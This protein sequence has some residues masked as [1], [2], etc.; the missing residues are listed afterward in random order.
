MT[1]LTQKLIAGAVAWTSC[2][3]TEVN[4][5]ASGNAV[6]S[7]VQIDNSGNL[8]M[9]MDVSFSLGSVTSAGTPYL[10][11]YWYPL[12]QDGSTYGDSRFASS[13]TAFPP[14]NYY[15]GFAGLPVGTQVLTGEFQLPGRRS[16]IIL[17][18]GAGKLVLYNG[19]GIAL[20]AS[21][22]TIK[23][24]TSNRQIV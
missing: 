18:V 12:N 9:F 1:A 14:Q 24:R 3:G 7:S 6:M 21:A 20:A 8:D 11:L 13:T 2:F 17:P 15:V 23:Y 10:G 4:S 19:A 22:N 5:L 16:P